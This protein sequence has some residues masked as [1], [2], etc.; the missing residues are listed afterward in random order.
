M[1]DDEASPEPITP[2]A[3][4]RPPSHYSDANWSPPPIKP[5]SAGISEYLNSG[6]TSSRSARRGTVPASTS[7]ARYPYHPT[8]PSSMPPTAGPSGPWTQQPTLKYSAAMQQY[9]GAVH[10]AAAPQY[11]P[12]NTPY[13]GNPDAGYSRGSGNYAS[14]QYTQYVPQSSGMVS[15]WTPA[16]V[17]AHQALATAARISTMDLEKMDLDEDSGMFISTV[18]KTWYKAGFLSRPIHDPYEN[19]APLNLS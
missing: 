1:P 19:Y 16:T 6:S 8:P 9:P 17:F 5:P 2:P 11:Y 12:N 7:S 14:Q 3:N 4:D 18:T 13:M 10:A 15:P